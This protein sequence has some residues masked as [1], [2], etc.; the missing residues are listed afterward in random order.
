V[1]LLKRGTVFK[2]GFADSKKSCGKGDLFDLRT[3][4]ECFSADGLRSGELDCLKRCRDS[5]V[6]IF[7]LSSENKSKRSVIGS[8]C[9]FTDEGK[10]DGLE[11]RAICE[12]T[13]TY[14]GNGSGDNYFGKI[15]TTCESKVANAY[16]SLGNYDRINS[17]VLERTVC[18]SDYFTVGRNYRILGSYYDSLFLDVNN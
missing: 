1:N 2:C 8:I 17:A 3:I 12:C 16:D 5:G 15:F 10:S 11:C 7:C 4:L 14:V 18:N 6:C 13:E 9:T